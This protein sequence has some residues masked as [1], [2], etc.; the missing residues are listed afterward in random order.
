VLLGVRPFTAAT[1]Y[2]ERMLYRVSD[3]EIG[4]YEYDRWVE[5]PE[6]MVTRVI[7]A[8]LHASGLFRQVVTV[9]QVQLPAWLLSGELVRFDEVREGGRSR[10]ECWLRVEVRRAQD[11]RLL[12][13]EVMRASVPLTAETPA[14]LAQAMSQAV[15]QVA[16]ELI[17]RLEH[18]ELP[19]P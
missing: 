1:R 2:R 12:W 13:T 3:V 7:T 4:F 18:T 14:A 17:A 6:E 19:L 8:L 16:T 10:A 5:P 11:E 15:Q 9:D